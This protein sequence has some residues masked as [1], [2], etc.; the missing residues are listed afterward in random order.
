MALKPCATNANNLSSWSA[1]VDPLKQLSELHVRPFNVRNL[2]QITQ[3]TSLSKSL[4][5]SA[6]D[7][8]CLSETRINN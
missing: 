6:I 8:Y 2:S 4:E 7:V 1:I 5:F 3:Q